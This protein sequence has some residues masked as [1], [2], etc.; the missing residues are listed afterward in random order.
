MTHPARIPS[1]AEDDSPT[2]V[3]ETKLPSLIG[4]R[5]AGRYEL[6]DELGRGAMGVV[7]RAADLSRGGFVALKLVRRSESLDSSRFVRGTRILLSLDHASIC[8]A[9]ACGH[10]PDYS[11]V[12]MEDLRA[13]SL[14]EAMAPGERFPWSRAV[15]LVAGLCDG[16]SLL[17][18]RNVVHRD[19]KLSNVVLTGSGQ[20]ERLVLIDFDLAKPYGPNLLESGRFSRA[21]LSN[22]AAT[23]GR[24]LS[25]TPIFMPADRLRG[26]AATPDSDLF[27]AALILYRLVTGSLPTSRADH[28]S[29]YA[30]LAARARPVPAAGGA[31]RIPAELERVLQRALSP[32]RAERYA[33]AVGFA[34]DL[35]HLL[36]S[37]DRP[38]RALRAVASVA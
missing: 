5:V 13:P 33:S 7:Y 26:Q 34:R 20:R 10:S 3:S 25:G 8:R 30:L 24:G 38:T 11:Y 29:L 9:F 4:H 37:S 15:K 16:L 36:E 18:A 27:A 32:R 17:H 22:P 19:V 35:R 14:S 23:Q 2:H 6:L 28:S 12:V 21:A 1:P 31:A